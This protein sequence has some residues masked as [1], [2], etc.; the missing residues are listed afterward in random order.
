MSFEYISKVQLITDFSDGLC[1]AVIERKKSE[2]T[3]RVLA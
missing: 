3:P 2:I 1:M